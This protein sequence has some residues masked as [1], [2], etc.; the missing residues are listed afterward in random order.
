MGLFHA[1][2]DYPRFYEPYYDQFNFY[3]GRENW[4]RSIRGIPEKAIHLFSIHWQHLEIYNGG[5]WQYFFNSTSESAPE[6]IAGWRAIGLPE[7]AEVTVAACAR[8]G[9]PLPGS[10]DERRRIVG[11]PDSR[12]DFSDLDALFYELADTP[13]VFRRQPRF[14][15]FADDYAASA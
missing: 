10:K 3:E 12:M 2:R 4:L 8:V 14:V 15:P 13:Q 7:V 11:E 6:A 1:P 5:F 9:S